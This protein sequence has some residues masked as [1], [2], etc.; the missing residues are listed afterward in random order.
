[1]AREVDTE[2]AA[3]RP[4]EPEHEPPQRRVRV[5][6]VDIGLA[7]RDGP[8]PDQDLASARRRLGPVLDPQHVRRPVSILDDDS[9]E[10]WPGGRQASMAGRTASTVASGCG[11][12]G[13]WGPPAIVITWPAPSCRS[14]RGTWD[15]GMNPPVA[16]SPR[17]SQTSLATAFGDRSAANPASQSP[18]F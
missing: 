5:A 17:I 4:P 7:H 14:I 3:A 12:C 1:D 6:H 18:F 10:L 11:R 13:E 15:S 2:D 9:P 16:H 8:D